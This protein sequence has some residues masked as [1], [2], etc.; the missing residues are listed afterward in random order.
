MSFILIHGLQL[1]VKK[2]FYYVIGQLHFHQVRKLN[3]LVSILCLT[4]INFLTRLKQM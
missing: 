3:L 2:E 4:F 1:V